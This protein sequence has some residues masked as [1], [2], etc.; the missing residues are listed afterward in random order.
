MIRRLLLAFLFASFGNFASAEEP[1]MRD[2]M[3]GELLYSTHCSE[4]HNAQVHWRERKIVT[5]WPSL[6][7]EV[8]RWQGVL[9]LG[10]SNGDI[11]EVAQYLNALYYRFPASD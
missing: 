4:C 6:Q 5:D 10:W 11:D 3:R 7:I 8:H 2:I 1:T 9:S